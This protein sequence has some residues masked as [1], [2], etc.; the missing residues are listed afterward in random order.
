MKKYAIYIEYLNFF[1]VFNAFKL[2][3][4]LKNENHLVEFTIFYIDCET[5]FESFFL[6]ILK[7]A[8]AKVEKLSFELKDIIDS[9]GELVRLRMN[10]FDLFRVQKSIINGFTFKALKHDSWNQD[11]ILP[12]LYKGIM[13]GGI[14]DDWS[15]TRSIFLIEV[16]NFHNLRNDYKYSFFITKDKAWKEVLNSEANKYNIDLLFHQKYFH[17]GKS[18]L[19]NLVLKYSKFFGFIQNFKYKRYKRD[20]LISINKLLL[21]GRGDY[22]LA[23][24]GYHTDFFWLMNSSF[25]KENLA[26]LIATAEEKEKLSLEGIYCIDGYVDIK[27]IKEQG[28]KKAS[29]HKINGVGLEFKL[30]E[31]ILNKYSSKRDYW[32]SIFVSHN[33][34]VFLTWYKYSNNHIAITDA[35]NSIGGISVVWQMAFDGFETI[36]SS[37]YSDISF[38]FSNFS[39]L[40]DRKIGSN[41]K[42]EIITGYPKDYAAS[43]LK[44]EA[45]TLRE[46]FEANGVKKIVFVIDENSLDDHRWHTGHSYQRENYSYILEEVLRNPWLGVVFKPKQAKNLR[47]RLGPTNVLLLEAEATGRCFVYEDSNR[48]TT[49]AP[50]ILAGLS[51]DV[52]IHSH[53][54]GGTAALECVLEGIPTLLIDREGCP[55]SKLYELPRDKVIFKNWPEAINAIMKYFKNSKSVKGFGDWSSIINDLDPFRDGLAAYRIGDFLYWLMEGFSKG[56]SKE[57]V[58]KDAA[59]KYSEKWGSDKVI[60]N[61]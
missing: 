30:I 40:V 31:S 56:L 16:F 52:C 14:N 42:Y 5:F 47:K 13:D 21:E 26:Y 43:L 51:A 33:I 41:S 27:E 57:S 8:F 20:S 35:I 46:K 11:R 61:N 10:R 34:K 58:M 36:E 17:F 6:Y 24:D 9:N 54:S 28:Y 55:Y 23:N 18:N 59:L 44:K 37:I 29:I 15:I 60:I 3:N 49:S 25:K 39:H 48:H 2:I 22:T 38:I 7:F 53:L 45:S 32:R 19:V 12:Y 4:K 50:P 1:S